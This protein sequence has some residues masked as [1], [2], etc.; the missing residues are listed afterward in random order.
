MKREAGKKLFINGKEFVVR[1]PGQFEEIFKLYEGDEFL[2]CSLSENDEKSVIVLFNQ[3]H[4]LGIFL[5]YNGDSGFTTCNSFG[6]ENKTQKFLLANAQLDE[7]SE[8]MLV[9]REM[10]FE[11]YTNISNVSQD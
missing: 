1:S 10:G 6:D 3:T 9:K 7:Y 8:T 5:R 11:I 2:D 4:S